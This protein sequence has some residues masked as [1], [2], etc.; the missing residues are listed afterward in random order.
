MTSF[1]VGAIAAYLPSYLDGA[2]LK[3]SEAEGSRFWPAFAHWAGWK[4]IFLYF[5]ASMVVENSY[6]FTPSAG[7]KGG[8][9]VFA[10]HPHGMLSID[11]FLFMSDCVGFLS[12]IAPLPRRDLGAS[13]I[14]LIPGLRELCLWLGVVD[15]GAKTAGKILGEGYSMQLY[16]GQ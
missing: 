7:G 13:V 9:F 1:A 14:F 3:V 5:P 11:H 8:Q 4:R 16:P 2:H 12:Q 6:D 15:A 10:V